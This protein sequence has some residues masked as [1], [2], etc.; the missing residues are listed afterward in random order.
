LTPYF[1]QKQE[2]M[3]QLTLFMFFSLFLTA[4]CAQ[5]P[6]NQ[7]LPAK[8]YQ[9]AL[10]AEDDK[11]FIDVRTPGEY[12]AGHIEGA[13]NWNFYDNDFITKFEDLDKN[14]PV[15][16]YCRSGGRSGKAARQLQSLGFQ[17]VVDLKGG[18]LAWPYELEK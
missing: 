13:V 15:Y 2:I 6:S 8:E 17:K 10:T 5:S 9:S 14:K 16:L 1:Y 18:I 7:V 4:A 3:K 11:Y 12:S